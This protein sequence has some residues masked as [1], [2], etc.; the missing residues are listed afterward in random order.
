MA[1]LKSIVILRDVRGRET[2]GFSSAY[3][4]IGA[5]A[6][7][8]IERYLNATRAELLFS[9]GVIFVEGDAEATLMP[10]FASAIGLNLDQLGVSVCNISG[11]HFSS[12]V[13]FALALGLPY[14]V[15]TDW[16]PPKIDTTTGLPVANKKGVP[17]P[18]LGI[19]RAIELVAAD[20][21][22]Q[23][24]ED[25]PVIEIVRLKSDHAY[26]RSV[27]KGSHVFMNES[28]LEIELVNGPLRSE[29]ISVLQTVPFGKKDKA[30]IKKWLA[31]AAKINPKELF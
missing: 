14:V 7:E 22:D 5:D 29:L 28:T 13:E 8:D 31:P 16:D 20:Y 1:P 10:A 18:P 6:R 24:H 21:R 26:L 19:D 15:V 12:Y 23:M 9:R 3:L 4:D 11:T 25:L 27:A 30:R 2:Q 17:K